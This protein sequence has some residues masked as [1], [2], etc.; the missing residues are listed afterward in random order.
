VKEMRIEGVIFKK[1]EIPKTLLKIVS[2]TVRETRNNTYH[3]L[4]KGEYV[5]LLEYLLGFPLE[6][7]I[8]ALEETELVETDI[9]SD[10]ENIIRNIVALRKII[11]QTSVDFENL[12]LDD[13]NFETENID[14]YL[15]QIESL[16]TL[17]GGELPEDKEK[18]IELIESLEEDKLF[19]KVNLV[20][21]FV[22]R[23]PE[24][25]IGAKFLIETAAKVYIVLNDRYV[26][27]ALLK[28]VLLHYP[29]LLDYSY[30]AVKTLE[31]IYKEEGN[32]IY[33]RYGKMAKVL[34][35]MLRGNA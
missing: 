13:F 24:E 9:E 17:S 8:I 27:K 12:V 25:Q 34:E 20:K 23:F 14:E 18:A 2:G 22:E 16:L 28:K 35:V 7:D 15:N 26:A 31:S 5:A 30:E 3:D 11:Y 33:R 29:H 6:D 1:G 21:K 10:Y 4:T 32:I 19:T